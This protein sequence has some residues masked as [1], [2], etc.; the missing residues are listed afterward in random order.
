MI[1]IGDDELLA[2]TSWFQGD[3][4][5]GK[6]TTSNKHLYHKRNIQIE[7]HVICTESYT[8]H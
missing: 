1:S 5:P 8:T 4:L 7:N 6:Y 3:V 2:D